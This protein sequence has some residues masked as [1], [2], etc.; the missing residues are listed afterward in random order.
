MAQDIPQ[1]E[2]EDTSQFLPSPVPAPS[3][4]ASRVPSPHAVP[5]HRPDPPV[6]VTKIYQVAPNGI[7][8]RKVYVALW[9]FAGSEGDELSV[10]RGDLVHVADPDPTAEWWAGEGLDAVATAKT[11]S[12]GFLPAT[13]FT[14]AFEEVA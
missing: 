10:Q 5:S 6:D 1:E 8:L 13:Y 14:A 12:F 4:H 11:G 7:D 9:D 3:P 2:Y